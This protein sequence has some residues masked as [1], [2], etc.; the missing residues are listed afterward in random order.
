MPTLAEGHLV[1]LAGAEANGP[2]ETIEG[3]DGAELGVGDAGEPA[4]QE[5]EAIA[6]EAE[7]AVARDAL[8]PPC[9]DAQELVAH[10]IAVHAVDVLHAVDVEGDERYPLLAVAGFLDRP[11][12]GDGDRVAAR[13]VGQEVQHPAP[14]MRGGLAVERDQGCGGLRA[15][16]RTGPHQEVESAGRGVL[17]GRSAMLPA[18]DA[19]RGEREGEAG[20]QGHEQPLAEIE[21]ERGQGVERAEADQQRTLRGPTPATAAI[22]V[23]LDPV[24]A[25][26]LHRRHPALNV[27]SCRGGIALTARRSGLGG[28]Q[29]RSVVVGNTV[30]RQRALLLIADPPAACCAMN[31]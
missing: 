4:A 23:G 24:A 26:A 17:S 8:E 12:E 19:D 7:D 28:R 14:A 30:S 25:L 27:Q 15:G 20:Q 2:A 22:A 10:G 3:G 18:T 29:C 11:A 9:H 21:A 1:L 16:G 6:V 13:Q 5:D 31:R